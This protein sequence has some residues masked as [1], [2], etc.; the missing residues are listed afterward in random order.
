MSQDHVRNTSGQQLIGIN[1]QMPVP[2]ATLTVM[3]FTT[4]AEGSFTSRAAHVRGLT[5]FC[6]S[7]QRPQ[8][9]SDLIFLERR[10]TGLEIKWLNGWF[11]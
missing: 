6:G 3:G 10:G 4:S 2:I 8:S 1:D 11:Y 5:A 9:I 7:R